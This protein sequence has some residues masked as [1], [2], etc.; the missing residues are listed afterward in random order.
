MSEIPEPVVHH[1][2]L[3]VCDANDTLKRLRKYG[4]KLFAKR[5][6][7]FCESLAVKLGRIILVV[8]QRHYNAV[9]HNDAIRSEPLTILCCEDNSQTQHSI[10][11]VFNLAFS[12]KKADLNKITE[13]IK[14]I[15][16]KVIQPPTQVQDEHGT[17]T[18]A[19]IKSCCGNIVH[20]LINKDDY[21]GPFCTGF[22]TV[23]S[24]TCGE[25]LDNNTLDI[26]Y[27]DHVTFACYSGNSESIIE[28]YEKCFGMNRF[29]I[30]NNHDERINGLILSEDVG[31]RLRAMKYYMCAETGLSYRTKENS[32]E[33]FMLV[34]VES[35][36]GQTNCNVQA[37]LN[38]HQS[39]GIEHVALSTMS[40]TE[41]VSSLQKRGVEFRKPPMA[42]Y[43]ELRKDKRIHSL[44]Q[45]LET[46]SKLGILLDNEDD[47]G[48][49]SE[50]RENAKKYLM[51]IFSLPLFDLKTFFFEVIERFGAKGLGTANILAL[52]LTL[53]AACDHALHKG[54][55]TLRVKQLP[56]L[57]HSVCNFVRVAGDEKCV[58]AARPGGL[59]HWV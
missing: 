43:D 56:F 8:S 13:N 22:E 30:G 59:F 12:V 57:L 25:V 53:F 26:D 4:F 52:P 51:Q 15:G 47:T 45:D 37:Y 17:L 29:Q 20:T 3:C 7:P 55:N 28:F 5:Q 27:I 44:N 9:I 34:V 11:T 19:I 1:L 58:A 39:E 35:L 48:D 2:E 21:H 50:S 40:I 31:L 32:P 38:D 42:Y 46:L 23:E 16:G 6:T 10:D 54:I 18:Y 49:L 24:D 14:S 41:T 36:K 33:A